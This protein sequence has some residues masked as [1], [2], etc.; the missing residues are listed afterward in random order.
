MRITPYFS[1]WPDF[2]RDS[3]RPRN[4]AFL[5]PIFFLVWFIMS[6]GCAT[7]PL[8]Y[9]NPLG[10]TAPAHRFSI[11][12]YNVENFFD[13][14]HNPHHEDFAFL[15][16]SE[17][18]SNPL[19]QN[20]CKNQP[21]FRRRECFSLDWNEDVV[22]KKVNAVISGVLQVYGQG[23]DIL[24]LEETES[25]E[26]VQRLATKMPVAHYQTIIRLEADDKRGI[27]VS[28]LSRFPLA[29]TAQIHRIQFSPSTEQSRLPETRGILEVPLRLPNGQTLTVF[30]VH[31]PSQFNPVSE[32]QDALQTLK[33]LIALKKPEDL[34]IIGGDWN[35]SSK[36]EEKYGL[37]SNQLSGM[38]IVSHLVGCRSCV[39]T[40][41]Y[42]HHWEF[43]D[44]LV[45]SRN[46]LSKENEYHLV[47]ESIQTPH[48]APDQILKSGEP[49]HFDVK[50][51]KGISDHLPIFAE[52]EKSDH[53]T[54]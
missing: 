34:W 21:I 19:V 40:H 1:Q 36:E 17:K 11:M 28:L 8:T 10:G 23:P 52:F 9:S 3:F 51:G 6:G 54:R 50:T 26:L 44:I 35:I 16:R 53:Q 7:H 38:G 24:L 39:G 29:G 14:R 4:L 31:L 13:S 5:F 45:F 22:Q 48:F 37:V 27:A 30:G 33:Q 46:F 42:N 49:H 15:P 43:L 32:R 20:Y 41:Y 25:T 12:A 47:T 2:A 18:K